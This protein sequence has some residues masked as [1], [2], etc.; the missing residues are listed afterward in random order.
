M[1]ELEPGTL[2]TRAHEA[3][4]ATGRPPR[5]INKKSIPFRMP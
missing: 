4:T 3:G 1:A 5:H 2:L